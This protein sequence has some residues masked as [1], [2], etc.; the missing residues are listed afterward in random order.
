[1]SFSRSLKGDEVL[2]NESGPSVETIRHPSKSARTVKETVPPHQHAVPAPPKGFKER[3]RISRGANN[4]VLPHIANTNLDEFA[5]SPVLGD[6]P[7]LALDSDKQQ[8]GLASTAD[9]ASNLPAIEALG[10]PQVLSELDFRGQD[11][12]GPSIQGLK[13]SDYG[14]GCEL[15]TPR[16]VAMPLSVIFDT[17]DDEAIDVNDSCFDELPRYSRLPRLRTGIPAHEL[18]DRDNAPEPPIQ[19]DRDVAVPETPIFHRWAD[20]SDFSFDGMSAS[21]K[22]AD[23]GASRILQE[24]VEID[25]DVSPTSEAPPRNLLSSSVEERQFPE[26]SPASQESDPHGPHATTSVYRDPRVALENDGAQESEPTGQILA[27]PASKRVNSDQGG[28]IDSISPCQAPTPGIP[29]DITGEFPSPKPHGSKQPK[30]KRRRRKALKRT[31][32]NLY[33][34]I[35]VVFLRRHVLDV[36]VGR[37]LG[38]PTRNNLVAMSKGLPVIVVDVATTQSDNPRSVPS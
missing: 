14:T 7:N 22:R 9:L 29:R 27:S 6:L 11:R 26:S 3:P 1:M 38:K 2:D 31:I 37:K 32:Q 12:F 30:T 19:H 24:A 8:A 10:V 16:T 5:A 36:I 18:T 33:R 34:D 28:P 13:E 23:T 21:R 35:R 15:T 20:G 25:D 4:S 17:E